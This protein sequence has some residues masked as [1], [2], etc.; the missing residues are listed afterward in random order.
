[1]NVEPERDGEG[2]GGEQDS[3]LF[4][5]PGQRMPVIGGL[6]GCSAGAWHGE[7]DRLMGRVQQMGGTSGGLQVVVEH[8]AD[9]GIALHFAAGVVGLLRRRRLAASREGRTGLGGAR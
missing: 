5:E 9:R 1:V 8:P 6:L 2:D 3:V 4:L 7:G